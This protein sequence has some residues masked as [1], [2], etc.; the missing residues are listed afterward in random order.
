M[1]R[2]AGVFTALLTPFK[3]GQIDYPSLKR[4]LRAQLDGGINGLVINGTTGESPTLTAKEKEDLFLFVKSETAG[5][6]PLVMGTGSNSTGES[7]TATQRAEELGADAVLAVVPYYN[8][9]PQRGLFQHYQAIAN[10]SRLPV[11]LYNVPSRT[12][13]QLELETIVELSRLPN[14]IGIKEATGN[15]DFGRAI[16][17]ECDEG[18]LLTSGDDGT[19]LDLI[20]VGGC[21][22]I[23]VASNIVPKL[24]VD[25]CNRTRRGDPGPKEEFSRFRGVNSELYSEANPIPIKMAAHLLGLIDS[26]ELRLPLVSLSEPLTARLVGALKSVELQ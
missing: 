2:F 17:D 7:V 26:P 22:V 25:W 14:V 11:I 23:S 15:L 24:M 16:A 18:F 8:R 20:G 12:I 4:L 21:G 13:T 1:N 3:N 5:K 9:P 6:V 10:A 19:F